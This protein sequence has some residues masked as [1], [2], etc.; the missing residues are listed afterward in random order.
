MNASRSSL[1]EPVENAVVA[2]DE[3]AAVPSFDTF[4][5][6]V[7]L[8]V[9]IACAVKLTAGTFE[10]VIVTFCAAGMNVYPD[11]VGVTV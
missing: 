4:T 5:S 2:M 11:F 9:M 1:P 6:R 8:T 7:K 10:P 3:L